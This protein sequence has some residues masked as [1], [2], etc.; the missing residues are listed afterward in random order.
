MNRDIKVLAKKWKISLDET[1]HHYNSGKEIVGFLEDAFWEEDD[2][3]ERLIRAALRIVN[4][5][6]LTSDKEF[7]EKNM[8]NILT[9]IRYSL[10]FRSKLYN[11]YGMIRYEIK[12]AGITF[13]EYLETYSGEDEED[14]VEEDQAEQSK[15]A[16]K[17]SDSA[18]GI[19]TIGLVFLFPSE[20]DKSNN[21]KS[22]QRIKNARGEVAA[23]VF[24]G[25]TDSGDVECQR[26]IDYYSQL[27]PRG[28]ENSSVYNSLGIAYTLKDDFDS[29]INYFNKAIELDHDN[30]D[31][32]YNRGMV[33]CKKGCFE[34]AIED[35]K[36]ARDK[37]VTDKDIIDDIC[38]QLGMLYITLGDIQSGAS[39]LQGLKDKPDYEEAA[40]ML[41]ELD[42]G[43][44]L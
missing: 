7:V 22:Y 35:F 25:N 8:L 4:C 34:D 38:Y 15:Q 14:S 44:L 1:E 2:N 32:Y 19:M 30:R 21:W 16:K 12:K 24:D 29:A 13:E 39:C 18:R 42:K 43:G 23:G 36:T 11:L 28:Y 5:E 10:P 20:K 6:D 17:F 41:K 37:S 31:A 3:S 26:I 27:I 40:L 33:S 9:A